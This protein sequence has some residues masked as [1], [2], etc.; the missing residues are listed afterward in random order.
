MSA[1]RRARAASVGAAVAG[2]ALLIGSAAM[3]PGAG[4]GPAAG[5]QRAVSHYL[6][7]AGAAGWLL[8]VLLACLAWTV[9][10]RTGRWPPG[11]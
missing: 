9:D 1:N 7:A 6:A 8:A 2:L 10:P 5:D 3:W 11:G 4:P